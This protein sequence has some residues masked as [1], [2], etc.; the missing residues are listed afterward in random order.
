VRD[1]PASR[2]TSDKVARF[3]TGSRR[4]NRGIP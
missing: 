3:M 4:K 2:A 1:T